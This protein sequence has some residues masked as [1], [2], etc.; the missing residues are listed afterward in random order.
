MQVTHSQVGAMACNSK[1]LTNSLS[2]VSTADI[3]NKDFFLP[4]LSFLLFIS[5]IV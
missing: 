2:F 5:H 1:E 4:D 3:E